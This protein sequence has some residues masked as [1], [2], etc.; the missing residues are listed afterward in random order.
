LNQKISI[1]S[2]SHTY[3]I[4]AVCPDYEPEKDNSGLFEERRS[5]IRILLYR[6]QPFYVLP[7]VQEEYKRI[8]N[9]NWKEE[10]EEFTNILLLDYRG[11]LDNNKIA[12]RKKAL[13]FYHN[14]EIDCQILAEA[15]AAGM[16]IILTCDQRF[17]KRLG[18]QTLNV[19][20][21]KP[22][23]YLEKLNIPPGTKPIWRPAPSNPLSKKKWWK[24]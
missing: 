18:S 5:M 2:N 16:D 17:I 6:H 9:L 4:E 20:I 7:T 14:K 19:K 24:I 11:K 23:E 12:M 21:L 8:K 3:L 13:L 10:H 22:T 15:E 1:D